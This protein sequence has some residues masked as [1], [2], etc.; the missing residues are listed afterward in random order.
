MCLVQWRSACMQYTP[1]C[2]RYIAD[3]ILTDLLPTAMALLFDIRTNVIAVYLN[4]PAD[5]R[6][7]ALILVA[8]PISDTVQTFKFHLKLECL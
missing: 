1:Y 5:W 7:H 8:I 2:I 3:R 6:R 4:L